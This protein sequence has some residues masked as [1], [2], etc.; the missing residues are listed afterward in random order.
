MRLDKGSG[1]LRMQ[2]V[3]VPGRSL[4]ELHRLYLRRID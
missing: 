1:V 3:T 2:A 4:M